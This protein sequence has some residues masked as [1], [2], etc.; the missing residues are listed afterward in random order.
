M[1]TI[2][3]R[4]VRFRQ[5][6]RE[7]NHFHFLE[8]PFLGEEDMDEGV[9]LLLE[10]PDF[11]RL[12]RKLHRVREMCACLV[13]RLGEEEFS[14]ERDR[15]LE[16]PSL[17]QSMAQEGLGTEGVLAPGAGLRWSI[18][19]TKRKITARLLIW[20][21]NEGGKN[22]ICWEQQWKAPEEA[23]PVQRK[24]PPSAEPERNGRV[25]GCLI[26]S[27]SSWSDWS[28]FKTWDK[29][30]HFRK[31][32]GA[33]MGEEEACTKEDVHDRC[34][35]VLAIWDTTALREFVRRMQSLWKRTKIHSS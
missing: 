21:Q 35:E 29:M 20:G 10:V 18:T 9:F 34:W 27:D 12:S 22:P 30:R 5:K 25:K 6:G 14:G 28:R 13:R 16:C 3:E 19:C 15:F 11:P 32:F 33:V 7:E 1:S 2:T 17:E 31:A 23:S 8:C 24:I 4:T 26:V